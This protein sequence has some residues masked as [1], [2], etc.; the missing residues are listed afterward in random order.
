MYEKIFA[1]ITFADSVQWPVCNYL[2]CN[3]K[4]SSHCNYIKTVNESKSI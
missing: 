4:D 2:L 3:K 1:K